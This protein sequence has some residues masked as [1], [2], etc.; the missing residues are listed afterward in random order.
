ML[1][2]VLGCHCSG[3]TTT[4]RERLAASFAATIPILRL[5]PIAVFPKVLHSFATVATAA[6]AGAA[7]A[8]IS[9]HSRKGC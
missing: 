2:L 6:A 4:A 1:P 9:T 8:T 7:T 5:S 3:S